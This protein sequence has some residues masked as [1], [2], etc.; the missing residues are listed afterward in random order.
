MDGLGVEARAPFV[1]RSDE[2]AW[3][4]RTLERAARGR[5]AIVVLSGE[6]GIGKTRLLRETSRR[7]RR[8]GYR[9][10]TGSSY[11][12]LNE[13]F[14]PFVDA[15][16]DAVAEVAPTSPACASAAE[17][18]EVILGRRA[19]EP[20]TG[21]VE[22]PD[23]TQLRVLRTFARALFDLSRQQPLLVGLDDVHW[24]DSPSLRLLEHLALRLDDEAFGGDPLSLVVVASARPEVHTSWAV[25]LER[26]R[27]EAVV[28]TLQLGGL[29]GP[30]VG[31][32]L[33][34]RHGDELA[35]LVVRRL[36]AVTR[37]NPLHLESLIASV[38]V[39]ELRAIHEG[40]VRGARVPDNVGALVAEALRALP[41]SARRTAE[42]VAVTSGDADADLIAAILDRPR[43]DVEVDLAACVAAGVLTTADP[44]DFRHPVQRHTCL[45]AMTPSSRQ[46]LHA[47]VLGALQERDE[48]PVPERLARHA[49][50]AGTRVDAGLRARLANEAGLRRLA[51]TDW[52]AAAELFDAA[53]SLAPRAPDDPLAA[54]DLELNAALCHSWTGGTDDLDDRFRAAAEWYAKADSS[55]GVALS[56]LAAVRARLN[57]GTWGEEID[58][59]ELEAQLEILVD[60]HPELAALVEADLAMALWVGGQSASAEEVARRA[61]GRAVLAGSDPA[62]VR[63]HT[64]LGISL[65]TQLEF[66]ESRS[67]LEEGLTIA[68]AG[69]DAVEE[70]MILIRLPLITGL[71]GDTR[72]C[73]RHADRALELCRRL[74]APHD[75]EFALAALCNLA[76]TQGDLISVEQLG[77]EVR[78]IARLTGSP[79]ALPF[80]LAAMAATRAV[81]GDAVGARDALD[82]L[83]PDDP[84]LARWLADTPTHRVMRGYLGCLAGDLADAAAAVSPAIVAD[85]L[86]QPAVL[87]NGADLA[88]VVEVA[89]ALDRPDL[90]AAVEPALA[91]LVG[92]GQL[93]AAG[94]P[95]LLPRALGVA[96]R[97][98]GRTDEARTR[99]E[100][101][102]EIAR[103]E[104]LHVE[105]IR[106]LLDLADLAA[107]TGDLRRAGDLRADARAEITSA[108][109]WGLADRAGVRAP[110]PGTR[111]PAPDAGADPLV[112]VRSVV[113]FADISGSTRVTEELGDIAFRHRSRSAEVAMRAAVGGA[114]G[115]PIEGI[116]LGDGILAEFPTP[117][118]AVAGG[119][120]MIEAVEPTG[121]RVH[122]GVHQG[123]VVRD[124]RTIFGGAVNLTA[125]I[126]DQAGPSELVVSAAVA[127]ALA[128]ETVLDDLGCRPLK[129]VAEP[130]RL[131]RVRPSHSQEHP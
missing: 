7:A 84:D 109:L 54:A 61:A 128:D 2:V 31:D 72:A 3:M 87:G 71:M 122:V 14:L 102:V 74:D 108:G 45:A 44:P 32:L 65:L 60:E 22:H 112:H 88:G 130:V 99:L 97:L 121:L 119:L 126:C 117:R 79:W 38:S 89:R 47:D 6:A 58:T 41:A 8:L 116:R 83:L 30:D 13:P 73:R 127:D 94:M 81:H 69:C 39:E 75:A 35:P 36:A 21:P 80:V 27:G 10:L 18:L 4:E 20:S 106:A 50:G 62:R 114:G 26:L 68:E 124:D 85:L 55:A 77:A 34:A 16:G 1:G 63:A 9:V 12:D 66:A 67:V 29:R 51:A 101:A 118:A 49:L 57:T 25:T 46:Q 125:R 100:E 110:T 17:L 113:L 76:G 53:R 19:P 40:D 115:R 103:R 98:D 37:G 28:T 48:A 120:A 56:H 91:D 78:S 90:A 33:R 86:E 11:E 52:A 95:F 111:P 42:V 23:S 92:R 105:R 82:G 93:C 24:A 59:S 123:D 5:P 43:A 129:G 107:S 70:L 96:A 15:L 104:D 131:Y 64:A